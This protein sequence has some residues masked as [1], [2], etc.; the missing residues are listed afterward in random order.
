MGGRLGRVKVQHFSHYWAVDLGPVVLAWD[1]YEWAAEL[2]C[3]PLSL[4]LRSPLW[5][6]WWPED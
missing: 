4:K 6:R 3:G 2:H 5:V 1:G